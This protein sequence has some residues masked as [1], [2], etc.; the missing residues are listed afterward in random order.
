[1]SRMKANRF[2]AY[3][4]MLGMGSAVKR[5]VDEA[6]GALSDLQATINSDFGMRVGGKDIRLND[7]VKK[8]LLSDTI[9]LFTLGDEVEDV[10]AITV[11][12]SK[13]F[14]ENLRRCVPLRGAIAHGEFYF[15]FDLDLILGVPLV[16]ACALAEEAQWLGI[17]VDEVTADRVRT[18]F[19][20]VSKDPVVVEWPVPL[21]DGKCERKNVVNWPLP[22]RIRKNFTCPMRVEDF[23]QAFEP[24]FGKFDSLKDRDQLKYRN[25]VQFINAQLD[26]PGFSKPVVVGD[27]VPR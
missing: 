12:C 6:W 7:R 22:L 8:R 26:G 27:S 18:A 5:N 1:M 16:C 20:L 10:W 23:Y 9:V 17:T 19:A 24:L 4:D 3:F 15:N 2:V 14:M 25:T 21:K 11:L 13:M